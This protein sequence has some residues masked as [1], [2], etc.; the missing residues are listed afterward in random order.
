MPANIDEL[1]AALLVEFHQHRDISNM[2][3]GCIAMHDC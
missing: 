3:Y 1:E 2:V